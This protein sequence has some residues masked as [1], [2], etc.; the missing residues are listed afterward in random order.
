[1]DMTM[2]IF[3]N[4]L[5]E[6]KMLA[7]LPEHKKKVAKA[8]ADIEKM[9]ELCQSPY[10]S[11][12]WGKQSICLMHMVYT[13]APNIPGLFFREP[14]THLIADFDNV[15]KQFCV[16]WNIIY[17][18]V[19][20]NKPSHQ[21][22]ADEWEAEHNKDGVFI[23]FARHESKAR[24][25]TLSKSDEHNIFTYKNG[26][27]RSCPLRLWSDMDVAAYV[28]HHEIPMLS[29]YRK[30]GFGIRTSAGIEMGTAEKPDHSEIGFDNM[31][32]E[33][34]YKIL[35]SQRRRKHEQA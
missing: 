12:S 11:L 1:M 17:F 29:L 28:A 30:F 32:S 23:G 10:V 13:L 16:K 9:L 21:L 6:G 25:F 35:E 20:L 2:G 33:Q 7:L 22:A 4:Q 5:R 31:T 19:M 26:F 34:K 15:I 14:E 24:R 8:R 3:D 18:D 27:R